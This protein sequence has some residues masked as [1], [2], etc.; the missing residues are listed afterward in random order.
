MSL[1][2]AGN[3]LHIMPTQW[4]AWCLVHLGLAMMPITAFFHTVFTEL[5]KKIAKEVTEEV[6]LQ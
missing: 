4:Q 6:S 2:V 1:H 5:F 3:Y